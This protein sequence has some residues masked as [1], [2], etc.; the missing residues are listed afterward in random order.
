MLRN[1]VTAGFIL[2]SGT[3]LVLA[4]LQAPQ[5]IEKTLPA[6]STPAD[7]LPELAA[8][9]DVK[10]DSILRPGSALTADSSVSTYDDSP[11]YESTDS[12]DF[13]AIPTINLDEVIVKGVVTPIVA[14]QDTLEFNAGSFKTV[15]NA[16]VEDLLKRLP[17]VEVGSDG[18]IT[19][20]GKTISKIL[21][22]G[23]E[24]FADDPQLATKNL[25]SEMV[26]KVQVIDRKSDLAR[27]TG[28]DD[29][30]DETVINLTVKK[31]M[32]RGWFGN[33]SAGYS[34]MDHRYEA[35]GIANWFSNGNQV[36]ILAGGNNVN[37]MGFGDMGRGRFSA[38]GGNGGIL[39]SQR[40]GLNFNVGNEEKFRIGGNIFYSHSDR[41][42]RS[43][44]ETQYL[45]PDSVSYNKGGNLS[46]DKG[47]SIRADLRLKWNIDDYNA[48][49]F[50]PRFSVDFRNSLLNDSSRLI[51]GDALATLV[52][53]NR[54][55][56]T[57]KGTAWNTSGEFIYNHKFASKPGRSFS[58]MANY[59]FSDTR[60]KSTSWSDIEYLLKKNDCEE[61]L[62]YLD[63]R[64]WSNT[65][66][67]R[68][69]WSE[70]L[71]DPSRG[72]YIDLAYKVSYRFN[73][74]DKLTYNL[75]PDL[76]LPTDRNSFTLPEFSNAPAGL[77]YDPVLSNRF[78]N[79][80]F[81]QELQVGYKKVSKKLN[82]NAGLVFAPASLSSTDL[83]NSDR[84]IPARWVWNV[85]PF[86]RLRL[87]F[88]NTSSLNIRY[89]SSTTQPSLTALQPVKDVS[90]PMNIVQGNPDLKPTFTQNVNMMFNKYSTKYQQSVAAMLHASYG[91]NSVVQR[92][93]ADPL[94]GVRTTDYANA[95]GDLSIF[96]MGMYNRVLSNKA[97][98]FNGR[99]NFRYS[100]TP[101]YIDNDFNRTGNLSIG[102]S[103]GLTYTN[104]WLQAS[105]NPTYEFEL[106]T[107]SLPMQPT[108]RTHSY[109]F[110]TNVVAT[111]PFGLQASTD[112]TFSK[113]SGY[114]AGYNNTTWEWNAELSYSFLRNKQLTVF[115]KAYDILGIGENITR[116]TSANMIKDME[117][118]DLSTYV[119]VGLTWN[120]STLKKA[121]KDKIEEEFRPG[122]GGPY[123]T[124]YSAPMGPPPGGSRS[125][126][127]GGPP[128]GGG[129]P[130]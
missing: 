96:G 122:H 62:R 44:S 42:S 105:L 119:M 43:H 127:H 112:L 115:V 97:F 57:N 6:L 50:R 92:T 4:A 117:M 86:L 12:L 35:S 75:D 55:A 101:G 52:N 31:D 104:D 40:F 61:L 1:K 106:V 58:I 64:Q 56:R 34:P 60:Q 76:Y 8:P 94:T 128:P 26:E 3:T 95:N 32:N 79:N 121:Q 103:V 47:H 77:E 108:R 48:I 38:F 82:L 19:S 30:D 18:S 83:I 20:G 41:D 11:T 90:D 36:T 17:G 9:I 29:G 51:A 89:R 71:G 27:M 120:F 33:V 85:G 14:K 39:T 88:N 54:N 5:R 116:T 110:E 16:T 98:T 84:N 49:E 10:P 69:T 107:N 21:V 126:G 45:F 99:L 100:S 28:V 63:S 81:S 73:N 37:E 13:G 59:A 23:K 7:S 66:S 24:F 109:G 123:G 129:R 68:I 15:T 25:P 87:K 124:P 111:L 74:A 80:Y 91:I 114:F 118:N 125:G 2:L 72:N 46:H 65:V 113:T 130:F 22:D 53:N 93:V 67:G 70:P 78:R 102:P